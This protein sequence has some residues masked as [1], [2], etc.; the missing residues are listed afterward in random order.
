MKTNSIKWG[1]VGTWKV[2]SG[3]YTKIYIEGKPF[4]LPVAEVYGKTKKASTEKALLIC[5]LYNDSL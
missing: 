4:G 1:I 5:Q 3:W 2:P